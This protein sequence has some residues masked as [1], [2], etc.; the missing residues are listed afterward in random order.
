[1]ET[2]PLVSII[3]GVY[4]HEKFIGKTLEGFLKQETS[5]PFEII[6]HDD[7]STDNTVLVIKKYEKQFPHLFRNIYQNENQLSQSIDS[8]TRITFAA[9][10]GKYIAICEGDDYWIDPLKLQ[11]QVDVLEKNSKLAIAAHGSY[12]LTDKLSLIDSPFKVDTIWSTKDILANNWFIMTASLMFRRSM[13]DL[14]PDWLPKISH[15]DLALIL[16]ASLNGDGY[17]TPEPMSVYRMAGLGMMSRF[18]VKDSKKYI[19]LLDQFNKKSAYKFDNEITILK[20]KA[21]I[22]VLQ[23]YLTQNKNTSFFS[24]KYWQNLIRSLKWARIREWP[25]VTKRLLMDKLT[26]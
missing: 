21:R 22:D 12:R 7:A 16:L 5:F 11:K 17:Y 24:G 23:R 8:V 26:K 4:N 14:S 13:I 3:C 10:R 18:T 2:G 9:A 15:G 25:Y 19:F 1:V 20:D 6:V